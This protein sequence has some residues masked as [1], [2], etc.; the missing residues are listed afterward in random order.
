MSLTPCPTS[1]FFYCQHNTIPTWWWQELKST[2]FFAGVRARSPEDNLQ[3]KVRRLFDAA[4]FPYIIK[5]GDLT[6]IK[7]HFGE[8]GNSSY[9][10]PVLVRPIADRIRSAGGE[11]F[12]TDTNTLY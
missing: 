3:N 11:P 5:R 1:K 12:L 7:V 4:G 9:V 10:S 8:E 6:A 2:V